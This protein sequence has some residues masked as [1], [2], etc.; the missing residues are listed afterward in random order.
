MKLKKAVALLCTVGMLTGM[1]SGCGNSDSGSVSTTSSGNSENS[2]DNMT[3]NDNAN[4]ND[5]ENAVSEVEQVNLKVWVPEDE[6]KTTQE[7]CEAFNEAY[8]EYDCTFDIAVVGVDESTNNL[9]TDPELAAD[10]F[11]LPS[12]AISQLKDAGLIYPITANSDAVQ[13]LYG[14]GAIDACT[15]DGYLYGIPQTPNSFFMFYNKSMYTDDEVKSLET[16]M[17]KDLGNDVYNFSY[18]VHDSWYL[19]AFF[20]A[21]GCTLFGPNGE[22]PTECSWN[23]ADGVDAVNY[24]IELVNNPKYIEDR[25]GIAGSL[26]KDGKLGALCSGAWSADAIREALG[27]D[28]GACALPTINLNG[29]DCQLSNFAD[30]RCYAVK[31][32][33]AHPMAAQLLVE[34]LGNEEN[35][36][37]RYKECKTPPTCLS[38]QDDADVVADIATC[39]LIAQ[40]QY[41]TPQPSIS[42]ISNYWTPVATLG[43][44]ILQGDVTSD[45][46]LESLDAV[47]DTILSSL[48]E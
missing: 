41:A 29:K 30:Y 26:M 40:T 17:S 24:V 35:Q 14:Q 34:W 25:D 7:M 16:M 32:N 47:V 37:I 48:T 33:T 13:S 46:A 1:L 31:S 3:V 18:T 20:Y 11:L 10:V 28:F 39:A 8:P 15:R 45:N 38:L 22:D 27:D 4:T 23:S 12:G 42:Q 2:G 36:L 6:I 21:A 9:E 43:E 5:S 44:S 19:E